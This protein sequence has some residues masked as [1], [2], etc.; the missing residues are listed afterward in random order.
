MLIPREGSKV[1][2]LS[3]QE[4]QEKEEFVILVSA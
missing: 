4:C 2:R 1:L 3:D